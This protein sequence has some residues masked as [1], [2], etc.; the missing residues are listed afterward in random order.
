MLPWLTCRC[1]LSH[2]GGEGCWSQPVTIWFMDCYCIIFLQGRKEPGRISRSLLRALLLLV[3]HLPLNPHLLR[4]TIAAHV[5]SLRAL[6]P[7]DL[8]A[9]LS[10]SSIAATLSSSLSPLIIWAALVTFST[11]FFFVVLLVPFL[12]LTLLLGLHPLTCRILTPSLPTNPPSMLRLLFFTLLLR[13]GA[14]SRLTALAFP[15]VLPSLTNGRF[16]IFPLTCPIPWPT[17]CTT[18]PAILAC[19][20]RLPPLPCLPLVACLS[21]LF[22]LLLSRPLIPFPLTWLLFLSPSFLLSSRYFLISINF[23]P[24]RSL[25][26]SRRLPRSQTHHPLCQRCVR[27]PRS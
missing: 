16:N 1:R 4:L 2:H 22:P 18:S 21:F 6:M 12:S 15:T 5:L 10:T 24:N 9:P 13:N 23:Q 17:I 25:G 27:C 8:A 19:P 14:N 11:R 20:P 26:I 7:L 3:C